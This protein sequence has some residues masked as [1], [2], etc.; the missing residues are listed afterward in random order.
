L[1]DRF[2]TIKNNSSFAKTTEFY[3]RKITTVSTVVL[4]LNWLTKGT[5]TPKPGGA[6]KEGICL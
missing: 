1:T 6:E 5:A 2:T 4:R 3:C